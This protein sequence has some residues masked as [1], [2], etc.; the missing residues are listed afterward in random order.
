MTLCINSVIKAVDD[1]VLNKVGLNRFV[2]VKIDSKA[3]ASVRELVG[4][5][6]VDMHGINPTLDYEEFFERSF[7]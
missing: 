1:N 5:N 2:L 4:T 6:T 3:W 7:K